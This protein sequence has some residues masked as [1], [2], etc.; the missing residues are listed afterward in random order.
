MDVDDRIK[1]LTLLRKE[2]GHGMMGIARGVDSLIDALKHMPT[3][4]MD[5]GCRLEMKWVTYDMRGN[6]AKQ[7]TEPDMETAK[8]ELAKAMQAETGIGLDDL[9]I[10]IDTFVKAIKENPNV[11]WLNDRLV[12]ALQGSETPQRQ[13]IWTE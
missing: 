8:L 6:N 7:E 10:Y 13:P 3:T 9:S 4:P 5:V 2:T 11:S 1:I 12:T